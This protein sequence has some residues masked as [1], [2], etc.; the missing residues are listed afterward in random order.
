M[1]Q[2]CTELASLFP[3]HWP[4]QLTVSRGI[5]SE[6]RM[7]APAYHLHSLSGLQTSIHM[8][9]CSRKID[10]QGSVLTQSVQLLQQEL[11]TEVAG[12]A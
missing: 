9:A 8:Q 5:A 3:E 11:Y 6:M 12:C 7:I 1:G 10:M 4:I 2:S